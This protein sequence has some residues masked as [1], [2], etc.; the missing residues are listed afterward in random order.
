M[1]HKPGTENELVAWAVAL[2]GNGVVYTRSKEVVDSL[3]EALR[4]QGL[5]FLP[6]NVARKI[7]NQL[8]DEVFGGNLTYQDMLDQLVRM[9][10]LPSQVESADLDRLIQKF[11]ADIFVNP[12]LSFTLHA[13]R[14]R[15][16][17]VGMITNSIHSAMIKWTWLRQA[18]IAE[19]FD[20]LLSSVDERLR[21]PDPEIF[22]QFARRFAL[23]PKEVVFV[24]HDPEEL[25]GAK[26]AG[27]I[28]VGLQCA[29]GSAD[30]Q[31]TRFGE[32]LSLPIWPEGKETT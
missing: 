17:R 28:T 3:I 18:G 5:I 19:L 1:G 20:L 23:K 6:D 2:D 15:G 12:Q 8:Q 13:L 21:K 27:L 30:F 26:E 14:A 16:V 25:R 32:L 22:R 7:Y 11:S 29:Q 4:K 9:W 24:G 10:G 31:I